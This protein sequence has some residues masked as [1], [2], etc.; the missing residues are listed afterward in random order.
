MIKM[1]NV[2]MQ[3]TGYDSDW[4]GDGKLIDN[5]GTSSGSRYVQPYKGRAVIRIK[6]NNDKLVISAKVDNM[7][8]AFINL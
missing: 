2:L 7:T 5:L 6:M 8:T 4:Q 1:F 3:L